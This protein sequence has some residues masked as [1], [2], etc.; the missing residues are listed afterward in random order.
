MKRKIT[1]NDMAMPCRHEHMTRS[2]KLPRILNGVYHKKMNYVPFSSAYNL[3]I[4]LN[5]TM[6]TASL[7]IPSPNTIEYNLGNFLDD[8]AYSEAMVSI[9]Q[10]HAPNNNISQMDS[11]RMILISLASLT[12]SI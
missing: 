1:I 8:I 5:S 4:D 10:K 9:L 2:V 11:S 7:N 3:N 6:V 12:R